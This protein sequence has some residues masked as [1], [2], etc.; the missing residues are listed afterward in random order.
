MP[1]I[2]SLTTDTTAHETPNALHH[3]EIRQM[4]FRVCHK[5]VQEVCT[6]V[7]RTWRT[8]AFPIFWREVNDPLRLLNMLTPLVKDRKVCQC[9]SLW[10]SCLINCETEIRKSP[11]S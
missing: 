5:R 8:D 1:S 10:T 6:Q 9:Y 2:A 4:I 7:C 11:Y 3:F